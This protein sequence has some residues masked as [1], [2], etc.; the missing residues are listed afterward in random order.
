[1]HVR[2]KLDILTECGCPFKSSILGLLVMARTIDL[3]PQVQ[4]APPWVAV[5]YPRG[6][7]LIIDKGL[8]AE[9]LDDPP[10]YWERVEAIV[11]QSRKE[12]RNGGKPLSRKKQIRLVEGVFRDFAGPTV[13]AMHQALMA[14]PR[15]RKNTFGFLERRLAT[16]AGEA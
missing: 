7:I 5:L 12:L 11:K 16:S 6:A 9:W 3:V 14:M 4:P 8:T 15:V 2:E 10:P 13:V 1:M